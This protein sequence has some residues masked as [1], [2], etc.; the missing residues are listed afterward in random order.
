MLMK[1][2][3]QRLMIGRY[4]GDKLGKFMLLLSLACIL[5]SW[6]LDWG[7]LNILALICLVLS[8]FRMFSRNIYARQQENLKFL[9]LTAG[10]RKEWQF[11]KKKF[12]ER[13]EYTYFKCPYCKGHLRVPRGKGRLMVRCNKCGRE[14]EK[15]S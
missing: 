5:L 9:Q 4:G 2:W 7:I 13:K 3:F 1:N 14:F 6:L 11:Q 15:V 12:L 10:L 8:Y